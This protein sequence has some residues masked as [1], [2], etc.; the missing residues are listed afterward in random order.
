MTYSDKKF[1]LISTQ[2]ELH[3]TDYLGNPVRMSR[4]DRLPVFPQYVATKKVDYL[5]QA[6][7]NLVEGIIDEAAIALPVA[8]ELIKVADNWLASYL[9]NKFVDLGIEFSFDSKLTFIASAI[10]VVYNGGKITSRS[11]LLAEKF[12]AQL[13][14]TK[15]FREVQ[16]ELTQSGGSGNLNHQVYIYSVMMLQMYHCSKLS[17]SWI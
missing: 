17:G 3:F 1:E 12:L 7:V 16:I 13:D 15:I 8:G 10:L 6:M 14:W 11:G 9:N 4:F 2:F 5:G